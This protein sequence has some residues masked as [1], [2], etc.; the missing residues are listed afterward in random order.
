MASEFVANGW[1]MKKLHKL[2]MTSSVYRESPEVSKDAVDRDAYNIYLSL[3]PA[4]SVAAR[5][6]R[7]HAAKF[8]RAESQDG[9]ATL[10]ARSGARRVVRFER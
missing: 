9:R 6:P 7:R 5:D 1:S 4:S 10:G 8:R 2:I 3:Q